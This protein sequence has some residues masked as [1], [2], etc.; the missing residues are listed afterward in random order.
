MQNAIVLHYSLEPKIIIIN[1]ISTGFSKIKTR[2]EYLPGMSLRSYPSLS[3]IVQQKY[4]DF[5]DTIE[6]LDVKYS[7]LLL[8][9]FPKLHDV[10]IKKAYK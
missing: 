7:N 1:N 4:C 6:M 3:V 8:H 5:R 9:T 2:R 10:T